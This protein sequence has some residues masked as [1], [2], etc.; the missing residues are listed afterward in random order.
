MLNDG[1]NK[2]RTYGVSLQMYITFCTPFC[3]EK[4]IDVCFKLILE[5]PVCMLV[6]SRTLGRF[7]YL[8][9]AVAACSCMLEPGWRTV[10]FITVLCVLLTDRSLTHFPGTFSPGLTLLTSY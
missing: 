1:A 4:E 8:S 5:L 2:F 10:A 7:C 3:F 6:Y 9:A